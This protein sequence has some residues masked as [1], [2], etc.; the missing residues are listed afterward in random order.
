MLQISRFVKIFRPCRALFYTCSAFDAYPGAFP[1]IFTPNTSHRTY[2]RT[3]PAAIAGTARARFYPADIDHSLFA[4]RLI[5]A[6][7]WKGH[8]RELRPENRF[9]LQLFK[10]TI[11]KPLRTFYILFIRPPLCE[12]AGKRVL[13]DK[14]RARDGHKTVIPE[15]IPQLYK[16]VV[17]IPVSVNHNGNGERAVPGKRIQIPQQYIRNAAR[18]NRHAE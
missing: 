11:C 6:A 13:P 1:Y 18:I 4:A 3:Q 17:K 15:N 16:R 10:D 9:L 12:S 5:I 7:V 2:V 8:P 14:R